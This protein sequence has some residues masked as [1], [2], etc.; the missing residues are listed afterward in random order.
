M[1]EFSAYHAKLSRLP[2][3]GIGQAGLGVHNSLTGFTSGNELSDLV[4]K[5]MAVGIRA[6]ELPQVVGI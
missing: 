6:G 4:Y 1:M 2:F 5:D 3:D